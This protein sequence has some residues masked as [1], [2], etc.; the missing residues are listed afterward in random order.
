[1]KN[2]VRT[3]LIQ[4]QR[5]SVQGSRDLA[6]DSIKKALAIDPGEMVITEILIS[7]ERAE[8]AGIQIDDNAPVG[9]TVQI[10][11][12]ER[13]QTPD[14]DSKL[15]K[16]YRLSDETLVSGNKSKALA[17]LKK[18]VELFPN[19]HEA[20]QKLQQLKDRIRAEKLIKIGMK[21][22]SEGD[23]RKAIIASRRAFNL[24]S[25]VDGLKEL[26]DL[27]EQSGKK[28][29]EEKPREET[30]VAEATVNPDTPEGE[31]LLWADR[32]R[33]AVQDD[34]FEEAGKM[35]AEAVKRYP[36]DALLDSFYTKLKRLGF[37]K[38]E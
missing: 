20:E 5:Y 25:D 17:Y 14:M 33:T 37:V 4:A 23:T 2:R 7:M 10:S 8:S 24:L 30:S 12:S 38:T 28:A 21:K 35:V 18:A 34:Q 27:I 32:I 26:I 19:D 13:N 29:D 16:I 11:T 3:H 36:D 6:L 15:E 9:N 1:M 22:L 31:A